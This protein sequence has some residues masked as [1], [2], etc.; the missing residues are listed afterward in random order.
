MAKE[1]KFVDCGMLPIHL[2]FC[3]NKQAYYT[4][5]ED[6][7]IADPPHFPNG[8]ASCNAFENLKGQLGCI[9]CVNKKHCKGMSHLSNICL[10]AHEA[11]HVFQAIKIYMDE[12]N[13]S[14]EF[15]AYCIQWITQ[16]CCEEL[17][18]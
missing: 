3:D 15:E 8:A 5:M 6:L 11:V 4:L 7:N 16:R 2:G 13:P 1:V 12:P 14:P 9:I 18:I 10:V 17:K